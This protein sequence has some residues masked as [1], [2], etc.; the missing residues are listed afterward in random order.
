MTQPVPGPRVPRA[1]WVTSLVSVAGNTAQPRLRAKRYS[2][3]HSP[4]ALPPRRQVIAVLSGMV[5]IS[6][7]VKN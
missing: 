4:L 5:R 3:K 1:L 2:Q 6:S 7:S